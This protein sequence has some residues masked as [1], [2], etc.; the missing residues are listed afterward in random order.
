MKTDQQVA[1]IIPAYNE[2]KTIGEVIRAF[3]EQD[4]S[5][6]IYVVDNNSSDQTRK[7]AEAALREIDV[8]GCV[9]SEPRQGKALAVRTAF[10]KIDADIY[11]MV[12]AD[13]TYP[14][15]AV[16]DLIAPVLSGTAEMVVGDRLTKGDYGKENKRAFHEGGNNVVKW[17]ISRLYGYPLHDIL[18]GYR[19]FSRRFVKTYPILCDGF[20]LEADLTLH[21][22]DKKMT[23]VE[24]PIEYRD[25]PDGSES[26]LNTVQDGIRILML[27]FNI[28]RHCKPFYFFGAFAL[29][30]FVASMVFGSVP[31]MDYIKYQFV[32]HVPLAV[33]AT[34]LSILAILFLSMALILDSIAKNHRFNF[35]LRL[36]A[37]IERQPLQNSD[38]VFRQPFLWN[39]DSQA[40][41][42]ISERVA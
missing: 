40:S 30:C 6:A 42:G 37:Y 33:L 23:L 36:L 12:D 41:A 19:A 39:K 14:A 3:A 35:E 17:L 26:K 24:V 32:Y 8:D 9:L 22:L 5:F 11:V 15:A 27:I 31:V 21:A 13:M 4:D 20:E 1:I 38:G 29:S 34:T 28:F 10:S 16:H 25:R 2:E 18:S 7:V